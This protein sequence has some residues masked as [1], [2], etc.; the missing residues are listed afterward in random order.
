MIDQLIDFDKR[1]FL[2]LNGFHTPWL[3]PVMLYISETWV[4][5]PLHIFLVY[6]IFKNFPKHAWL[7]LFAIAI[8]ITIADQ[9]T[10]SIMK[11]YFERL[12]PS[13]D[14]TLES[15]VHIVN[16]EKGGQF[17]F[18][19]SHAANTFALATFFFLLFRQAKKWILLLFVW[20]SIVTYSRI[21][22][23]VHFPGDILVGA[24]VGV[25]AALIGYNLYKIISAFA[26]KKTNALG[27]SQ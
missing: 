8:T 1:L 12:R 18:A 16:E 15:I 11:P 27:D 24:I 14:P 3:D 17:G 21:Y 6:L 26:D 10:T 19:S 7:V 13:H 20:S 22:L 2:W 4:W 9:V 5:A 23:G 25:L